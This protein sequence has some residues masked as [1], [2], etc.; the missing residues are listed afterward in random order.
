KWNRFPAGLCDGLL[1]AVLFLAFGIWQCLQPLAQTLA[2]IYRLSR[3]Q[4]VQGKAGHN[5]P[6]QKSDDDAATLAHGSSIFPLSCLPARKIMALYDSNA[7]TDPV[8]AL[9]AGGPGQDPAP[10]R[11]PRRRRRG[12]PPPLALAHLARGG[13]LQ[14]LAWRRAGNSI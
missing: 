2:L 9:P 3:T 7:T 14:Q 1:G 8:R 6:G 10:P 11:P 4:L 13:I 12:P 5:N